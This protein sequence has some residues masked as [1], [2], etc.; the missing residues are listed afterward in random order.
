MVW[1]NIS[2]QHQSIWHEDQ[3][4]DIKHSGTQHKG[5]IQGTLKVE[6]SLLISRLTGLE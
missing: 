3:H 4:N 2:E 6:V 5:F 1:Q